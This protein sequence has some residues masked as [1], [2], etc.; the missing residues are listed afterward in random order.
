MK[1]LNF[2]KISLK[3]IILFLI[4][5]TV[6][7]C[8]LNTKQSTASADIFSG[9]TISDGKFSMEM[10][11]SARRQNSSLQLNTQTITKKIDDESEEITYYCFNWSEIS[12]L[13]FRFKSEI[14][15]STTTYTGYKFLLTNVQDDNL[16]TEVSQITEGATFSTLYQANIL[17]NNFSQFD[18]YYYI[19]SDSDITET[20]TRC[21]GNDFGLYK[22]DFVYSYN[23]EEGE[24]VS[25]SIGAI[26]VA[27]V[28]QD[29]STVE[30]TDLK[31]L[32]SVSSSNKLMNIFKLYLSNNSYKYVNPKYIQWIVV[33]L[34][35]KNV[36]YVLTEKI[37]TDNLAQYAN[38]KTIWESLPEGD[39]T[40]TEFIFDS[41]DIEGTWT[42]YCKIQPGTDNEKVLSVQNLST[43][44]VE[45]K[46]YVWLIL[47][48]LCAVI[49]IGGI[50]SLIV[51]NSKKEKVW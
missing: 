21:K 42:V 17:A 9:V 1:S 4:V 8:F 15:N 48:I 23:T 5:A 19:D 16:E 34:D 29:I 50:V 30:Q 41:N 18:F 20:T 44:K 3:I 14:K 12:N 11:A 31:I 46:S 33:G 43:V 22:F 25:V 38:Y 13:Q 7:M 35:T 32:Y 2:G 51:F 49:L 36:N 27:I 10:S 40:G 39:T 6:G 26:Y 37:K 24:A 45:K 28:P 47:A